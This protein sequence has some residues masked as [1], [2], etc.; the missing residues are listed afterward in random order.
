MTEDQAGS[1]GTSGS[2]TRAP[3]NSGATAGEPGS[4]ATIAAKTAE[5]ARLAGRMVTQAASGGANAVTD[6]LKQL[7]SAQFDKGAEVVSQFAQSVKRAANDLEP[8]APPL[9]EFLRGISDRMQLYSEDLRGQTVDQLVRGAADFTR[10]RPGIVFG[11]AAAAGFVALRLAM[12]AS[13][14][15]T[16]GSG[17]VQ[18]GP[19]QWHLSS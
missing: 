11:V 10:Q 2:A 13:A 7:A 9:A 1:P 5:T 3:E 12:T 4:A 19:A 6:E 17:Q 15:A 14:G 8:A 18:S 16:G